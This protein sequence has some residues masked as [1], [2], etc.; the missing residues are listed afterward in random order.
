MKYNL[1]KRRGIFLVITVIVL[2][3]GFFVVGGVLAEPATIEVGP[4]QTY[5]TIQ[6]AIE[7][8]SSGDIINVAAGTYN[9]EVNVNKSL[10][11]LG[12]NKDT[13][14]IDGGGVQSSGAIDI[15]AD[16]VTVSGFTIR[17][18]GGSYNRG[19]TILLEVIIV[20]LAAM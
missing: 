1:A 11:L 8:A 18:R 7:V 4:G 9:E 15:T 5:T 19:V 3:G 16:Y 17:N 13:T 2:I 14:I 10:T 20:R 12:K 6:A